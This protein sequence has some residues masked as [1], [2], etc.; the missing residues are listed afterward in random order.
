MR[1]YARKPKRWVRTAVYLKFILWVTNPKTGSTIKAVA[2]SSFSHSSRAVIPVDGACPKNLGVG[3]G[4][5]PVMT[6]PPD[7]F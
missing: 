1:K 3:D 6:P 4:E 2:K 5:E 7:S